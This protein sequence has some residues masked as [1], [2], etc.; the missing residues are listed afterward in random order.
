[1][2]VLENDR[3]PRYVEGGR[4]GQKKKRETSENQPE[5]SGRR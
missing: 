3:S 2:H 5:L 1:M 4:E